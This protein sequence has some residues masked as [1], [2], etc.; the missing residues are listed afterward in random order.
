MKCL[1]CNRIFN[2]NRGLGA[3]LNKAH[4]LH[5]Q[6]YYDKY[7]MKKGEDVCVSCKKPTKFISVKAGYSTSCSIRCGKL[8]KNNPMFGKKWVRSEDGKKLF[9]RKMS[10]KKHHF[11]GKKRLAKTTRKISKSLTGRKLTEE[12]KKNIGKAFKLEKHPNWL[13]GIAKDGYS[14]TFNRY[15]KRK[16]R[17]RDN[18]K[19]QECGLSEKKQGRK[20]D[21]H[22]I[23][24]DKKND[25]ETNLISLCRSCHTKTQYKRNNWS[26]YFSGLITKLAGQGFLHSL[27]KEE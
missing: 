26:K 7:L 1:I 11:Y 23:D 27:S 4:Q 18:F 15:L 8:G 9:S 2:T 19:C 17:K 13:G 24:Y 5:A 12:H 10:G 3:H 25:I 16:I 21:V 6:Q 20:L 14:I 22:H